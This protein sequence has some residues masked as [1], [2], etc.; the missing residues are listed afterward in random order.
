M[1]D[2][3]SRPTSRYRLRVEITPLARKHFGAMFAKLQEQAR[4]LVT[5]VECDPADVI[6]QYGEQYG[7]L[8][9]TDVL[10]QARHRRGL[11]GRKALDA[12]LVVRIRATVGAAA[13]QPQGRP[14]ARQRERRPSG[15]RHNSPRAR[16]PGRSTDDDPE[17]ARTCLVCGTSLEGRRRHAKTCKTACRVARHRA[18]HVQERPAGLTPESLEASFAELNGYAARL[19][20]DFAVTVLADFEAAGYARRLPDGSFGATDWACVQLRDFWPVRT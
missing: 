15:R 4:E 5:V 2:Q 9:M 11:H 18:A 19:P 16:S 14:E 20:D 12:A 8:T 17:P 7:D 3:L 1:P 6:E 10:E 13:T